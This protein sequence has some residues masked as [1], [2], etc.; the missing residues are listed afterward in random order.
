MK[1]FM[2]VIILALLGVTMY[3][4]GCFKDVDFAYGAKIIRIL[5]GDG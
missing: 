3:Q 4:G 1:K 5:E 2:F